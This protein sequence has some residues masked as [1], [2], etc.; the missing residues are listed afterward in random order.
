MALGER[1]TEARAAAGMNQAELAEA[2]GLDPS[3]VSHFECGRRRP[4][5]GNLRKL[6]RALGCSADWLLGRED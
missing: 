2:A 3:A 5:V 6:V 4:S 1:I